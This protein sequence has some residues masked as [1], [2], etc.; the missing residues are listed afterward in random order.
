MENS[1]GIIGGGQL[2]RMLTFAAKQLGFYVVILDPTEKS[3]AGQ[4]ADEQIVADFK[5][6]AAILSLAEKSSFVTFE[7]ELTNAQV[8]SQIAERGVV[9]HPSGDT[10]SVIQDKWRQKE[11]L[12]SWGV[13]TVQSLLVQENN[14]E[15]VMWAMKELGTPVVLKARFDAY[16]GRGNA[17]IKNRA[18]IPIALEKLKGRQLYAEQYIPFERE[19]AVIAARNTHGE[20]TTYHVV[21]TIQENNICHMVVAP[22]RTTDDVV[23]EATLL[24]V[25]VMQ[26]LEGAGVFGIEMFETSDGKVLVNE[27]APRVHN[28]G[29]FSLGACV[30]S[31]FE[32]HIRAITGM[33]LGDTRMVAPVAVMVN[34]L[35]QRTGKAKIEGLTAAFEQQNVSV[36]IYGKGETRPERKMGHITAIGENVEETMRRAVKARK[37]ISI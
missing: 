2:G 20:I 29:H 32:Q 37:A 24:A 13:P 36:H 27:I 7:I 19:L 28:S 9:V 3:P 25:N 16:D 30:T 26:H 12:T 22:A 5:D 14:E 21:E 31:Q 8:L 17:V 11:F 15:S 4:V 10:L 35:G 33:P 1:I 23:Y 34:I 18:D 6:E